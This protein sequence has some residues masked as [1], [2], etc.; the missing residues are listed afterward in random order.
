MTPMFVTGMDVIYF[1]WDGCNLF[2]SEALSSLFKL[3]VNDIAI[4]SAKF[5][6]RTMD[7]FY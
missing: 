6:P 1:D 3:K 4:V 5:G 2:S 7:F